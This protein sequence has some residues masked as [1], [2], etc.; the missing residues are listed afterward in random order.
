MLAGWNGLK[1]EQLIDFVENNRVKY[2]YVVIYGLD[3]AE[4]AKSE[5]KLEEYR[6]WICFRRFRFVE[7]A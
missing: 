1:V 5:K 2:E 7:Q 3:W 4:N 6:G